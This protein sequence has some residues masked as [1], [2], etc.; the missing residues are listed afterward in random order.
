MKKIIP[1]FLTIII[2]IASV[3]TINYF[4]PFGTKE[5]VKEEITKTVSVTENETIN[6]SVEKIY[7]AVVIV[8]TYDVSKLVSTG[9]GFVYKKDEKS[10]YLITNYHVIEDGNVIKVKYTNGETYLAEV[11]GSDQYL[12]IAVLSVD[13]NSVLAV[14]DIGTS[15]LMNL[16]DTVFTVGSPLGSAYMGTVTKGILSGKNRLVTVTLSSASSYVTEV[17]QTDAAINPGNSGGPL[18]NING[19]VI[20]VNSLKLVTDQI[21]GMGFAIPIDTVMLY[22]EELEKGIE[23]QRPCLGIETID[24][25]NLIDLRRYRITLP[26]NVTEGVVITN[27]ISDYPAKKA[28]LQKSDIIL[29]IDDNKIDSSAY[30]KYILYKYKIGDK[31]KIKYYRNNEIK[32]IEIELDRGFN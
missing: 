25:S 2:T 10:G 9:T 8:E 18:V 6:S 24:V 26:E 31:I 15:N 30:L 1:Y 32:E 20:G 13:V 7:D 4:L 22:I 23:I 12:D 11:L 19:Q 5:V 14:A 16:G 21:E 3:Y 28:G 27:V 29:S 17:L